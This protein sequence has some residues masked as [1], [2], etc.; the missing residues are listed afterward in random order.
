MEAGT[1]VTVA[2]APIDAPAVEPVPPVVAKTNDEKEER[3][4]IY[5]LA[6]FVLAVP[7]LIVLAVVLTGRS[8]D[9]TPD[10]S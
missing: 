10:R 2:A 6:L 5:L 9:V 3:A 8:D 7:L 4:G 1:N